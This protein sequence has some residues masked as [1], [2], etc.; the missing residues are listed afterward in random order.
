VSVTFSPTTTSTQK[1]ECAFFLHGLLA[2]P[3]FFSFHAKFHGYFIFVAS[4]FFVELCDTKNRFLGIKL[5][6]CLQIGASQNVLKN[7]L[8]ARM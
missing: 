8:Y 6:F 5:V 4:Y 1:R 7:A 3:A 2:Y